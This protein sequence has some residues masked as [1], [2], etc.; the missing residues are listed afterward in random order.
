MPLGLGTDTGRGGW[1]HRIS[2]VPAIV[3][4]RPD[5]EA[6]Q[7]AVVLQT[8]RQEGRGRARPTLTSGSIWGH[9]MN[10]GYALISYAPD[11]NKITLQR[12]AC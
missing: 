5:T 9:P 8:Q 2:E 6:R 3:F 10:Y 7:G 12:L 1:R 11:A 4:D